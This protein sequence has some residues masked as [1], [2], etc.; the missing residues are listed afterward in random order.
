MI[1]SKYYFVLRLVVYCGVNVSRGH[2][3]A[4]VFSINLQNLRRETSRVFS[5]K[6]R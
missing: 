6:K 5:N 4:A 3:D 1:S 2:L